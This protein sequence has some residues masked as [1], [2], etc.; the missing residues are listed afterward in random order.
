LRR[1]SKKT[2]VH[3]ARLEAAAALEEKEA[4]SKGSVEVGEIR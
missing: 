2:R 3:G 1:I 4:A